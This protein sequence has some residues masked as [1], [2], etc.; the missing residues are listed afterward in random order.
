MVMKKFNRL[1]SLFFPTMSGEVEIS[2]EALRVDTRCYYADLRANARGSYVRLSERVGR[3]AAG[4]AAA[5][6]APAPADDSLSLAAAAAAAADGPVAGGG[7]LDTTGSATSVRNSVCLPGIALSWF[8]AIL[9]YFVSYSPASSRELPVE[10]KICEC[11]PYLPKRARGAHA[12]TLPP[13]SHRA[14][15]STHPLPFS[16][17][18][19]SVYFELGDHPQKGTFLRLSENGAG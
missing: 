4:A 2:S 7:G 6:P 9:E 11:S 12:P 8:A 1:S 14:A 13:L 18:H 5:A 17:A 10:N 16:V 15:P 19:F 3:G